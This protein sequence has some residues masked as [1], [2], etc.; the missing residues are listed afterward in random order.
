MSNWIPT[1]SIP[2]S[3]TCCKC[4]KRLQRISLDVSRTFSVM[5]GRLSSGASPWCQFAGRGWNHL[6]QPSSCGWKLH[7][8]VTL[9]FYLL[10]RNNYTQIF[11]SK[12]Q[13]TINIWA[14]TG[15][16]DIRCRRSSCKRLGDTLFRKCFHT[17]GIFWPRTVCVGKWGNCIGGRFRQALAGWG[18]RNPAL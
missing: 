4:G 7:T 1:S 12:R 3:N 2:C 17:W 16:A 18:S 13:P 6:A 8:T 14:A 9:S 10:S 11:F 15:N 5:V